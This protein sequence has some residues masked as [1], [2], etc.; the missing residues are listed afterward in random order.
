[1]ISVDGITIKTHKCEQGARNNFP[2]QTLASEFGTKLP[3]LQRIAL[4]YPSK[5]GNAWRTGS[6]VCERTAF[7]QWYAIKLS[8]RLSTFV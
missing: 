3:L 4:K 2:R 6:I 1:M 5:D 7:A 8:S